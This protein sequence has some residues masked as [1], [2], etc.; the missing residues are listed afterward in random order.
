MFFVIWS[1]R[2][3]GRDDAPV[4]DYWHACE[5]YGDALRLYDAL[6]SDESTYSATIAGRV[7]ASTDYAT[8]GAA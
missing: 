5:S 4:L 2:I 7:I 6:L 3:G 8:G 1:K